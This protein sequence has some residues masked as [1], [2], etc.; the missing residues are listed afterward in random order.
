MS[1]GQSL[2]LQHRTIGSELQVYD[3]KIGVNAILKL[4][5]IPSLMLSRA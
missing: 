5:A 1:F 3:E 4:D 2:E